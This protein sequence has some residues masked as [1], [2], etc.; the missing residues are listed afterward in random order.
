MIIEDI[1]C[2]LS[3]SRSCLDFV[4]TFSYVDHLVLLKRRMYR[5]F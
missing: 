1:R 2:P 4:P 3:S 5:R